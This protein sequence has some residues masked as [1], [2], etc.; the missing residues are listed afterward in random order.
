VVIAESVEEGFQLV[1]AKVDIVDGHTVLHCFAN[2]L[3]LVG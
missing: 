1:G 3:Q 2:T